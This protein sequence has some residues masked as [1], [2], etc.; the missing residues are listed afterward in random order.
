ME[1]EPGLLLS[2]ATNHD[3]RPLQYLNYESWH[4]LSPAAA[5]NRLVQSRRCTLGCPTTTPVTVNVEEKAPAQHSRASLDDPEL[6]R[7][8]QGKDD[9]K[10]GGDVQARHTKKAS[11]GVFQWNVARLE[12]ACTS[13]SSRREASSSANQ[14]NH[15]SATTS[16]TIRWRLEYGG[17]RRRHPRG[18]RGKSRPAF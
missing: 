17:F 9:E 13:G 8:L 4:N 12:K 14:G 1:I 10:V 11:H 2:L 7:V 15:M 16:G 6:G 18:A 5:P 3:Y